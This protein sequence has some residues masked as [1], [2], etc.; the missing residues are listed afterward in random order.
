MCYFL[1]TFLLAKV[2]IKKPSYYG[3]KK[4]SYYGDKNSENT[5]RSAGKLNKFIDELIE[6]NISSLD[7][8][9]AYLKNTAVTYKSTF[10]NEDYAL[11]ATQAIF[12]I[13]SDRWCDGDASQ[14]SNWLWSVS[15]L[16]I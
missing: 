1:I 16:G 4:P 12:D 15:H 13:L 11:R 6:H 3:G 5:K 8:F 9:T 14:I 2:Y 10:R 7:N